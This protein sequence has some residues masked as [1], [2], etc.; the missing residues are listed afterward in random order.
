MFKVIQ[1]HKFFVK[2]SKSYVA[3]FTLKTYLYYPIA[4]IKFMWYSVGDL[5]RK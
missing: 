1:L 3:P 4:Y 5:I 2:Q